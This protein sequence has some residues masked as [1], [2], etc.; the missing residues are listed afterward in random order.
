MGFSGIGVTELLVI[1][2]IV[3]LI[4]GTKRLKSIGSDL[5]SA[6]KGFRSAM[7]AGEAETEA[8]SPPP[9]RAEP[10]ALTASPQGAAPTSPSAGPSSGPATTLANAQVHPVPDQAQAVDKEK[11]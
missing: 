10:P 1:L 4:F 9:A 7:N 5:G 8:E 11:V 2:V 3:M 6:I